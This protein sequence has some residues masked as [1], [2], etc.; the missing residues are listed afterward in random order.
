MPQQNEQTQIKKNGTKLFIISK[1]DTAKRRIKCDQS[2]FFFGSVG[3]SGYLRCGVR[4]RPGIINFFEMQCVG[5][6]FYRVLLSILWTF[7]RKD[8]FHIFL[9]SFRA[10]DFPVGCVAVVVAVAAAVY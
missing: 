10:V 8:Y 9:H 6:F 7:F 2:C 1:S 5:T 3:S 4:R